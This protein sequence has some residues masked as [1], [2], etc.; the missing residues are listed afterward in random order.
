MMGW[1]MQKGSYCIRSFLG[2]VAYRGTG[3]YT[4]F[5]TCKIVKTKTF[6]T[7]LFLALK[8]YFILIYHSMRYSTTCIGYLV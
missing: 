2:K 4:T 5:E 7:E 6:K 1:A 3:R 8:E